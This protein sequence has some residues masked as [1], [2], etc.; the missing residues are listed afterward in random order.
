[1]PANL[2]FHQ[3]NYQFEQMP[4]T[5]SKT[6]EQ[7]LNL[8]QLTDPT[9]GIQVKILPEC[10]ALLHEFSIPLKERRLQAVSSYKDLSDL[11][12]NHP[13][14][15][16]SAKLSPFPCRV[17]HGRYEFDGKSYEFKNKFKDGS[18]IHGVLSDNP[19][20]FCRRIPMII[21]LRLRW[22]TCTTGRNRDIHL[23]ID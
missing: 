10:G 20:T 22:N 4:F 8:L 11:R 18:A 17:A 2:F 7:D 19:S 6:T 14:F 13:L 3:R 5:I 23:P 9:T 16:R 1:L 15:Y 12:Q 21:R